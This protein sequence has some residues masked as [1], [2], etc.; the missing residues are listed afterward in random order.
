MESKHTVLYDYH[1]QHCEKSHLVP[2][3]GYTM[4]LWYSSIAS[5]HHSVREKAGLFDCTHM[6]VW[7]FSGAGAAEFLDYLTTNNVRK[8]QPGR[9]QYS[10]I[11]D[12]QGQVMDDIIVYCRRND[13]IM[14]VV[15]AANNDKLAAH[16]QAAPAILKK[17]GHEPEVTVRDMRNEQSGGD[18]RVDIA[19]QGPAS[20]DIVALLLDDASDKAKLDELKM[21]RF[22]ETTLLGMDVIVSRTGYTGAP[23][24]YEL[25]VAP[26]EAMKLWEAVLAKGAEMGVQPCGLGARDSLRIEAGFPLYGHELAGDFEISPLAAGYSF[27]VKLDKDF[28]VGQESL[29][30]I[31]ATETMSIQRL[32]FPGQKGVRPVRIGDPILAGDGSCLGWITSSTHIGDRQVAL[33]LLDNDA[34]Q[35]GD[36]VGAYYL[37]RNERH[38]KQGRKK[39][40]A[41]GESVERDLEGEVLER[42]ERF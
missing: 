20:Q 28:F 37:A 16:F 27:A 8:L 21:F 3:A 30:D 1:V 40:V 38:E 34:L 19:L 29:R 26:D 5:E 13:E 36:T 10:Y 23:L 31:V 32:E 4:P 2:F 14:M 9:A 33:A 35:T 42:M 15:N 6:G 22:F 17:Y 12:E 25:F 18:C 24:G 41:L 7:S 11:L 39:E